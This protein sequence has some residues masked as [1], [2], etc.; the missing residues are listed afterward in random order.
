MVVVVGVLLGPEGRVLLGQR[1]AHKSYALA[2]EFP[3][4]KVEPGEA[5]EAA[6]VRELREELA[7]RAVPSA[8]LFRATASYR[9]GGTFDVGYYLVEEW[10][11]DIENRAFADVRWLLPSEILGYDILEGNRE[12]CER[13]NALQLIPRRP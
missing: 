9:D 4:G 8:L 10:T 11:G 5:P 3:G 12:F 2:W 13:L 7:I 6:L 1:P